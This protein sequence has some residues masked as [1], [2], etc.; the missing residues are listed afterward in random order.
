MNYLPWAVLA[1]LAYSF[2][3]PL[4]REATSGAGAIPSDVAALVAN[5]ILI[6]VTVGVIFLTD[7]NVTEHLSSPNMRLVV[8][9]GVCLSVGILAYYRAL[10]RGPVSVVAPI[11]GLF[12]VVAAVVGVVALDEPVTARKTLGILLA[13]VAVVLVAGD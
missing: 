6:V 3:A 13:A 2:V 5:T 7:Q 1:L 9:A 10:A 11:F 12:L 4:M 8:A